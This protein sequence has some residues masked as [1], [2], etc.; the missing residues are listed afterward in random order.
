[1]TKYANYDA[2]QSLLQLLSATELCLVMETDPWLAVA[3]EIRRDRC[4]IQWLNLFMMH[5]NSRFEASK[6]VQAVLSALFD[7]I[8]I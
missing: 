6:A 1:M 4:N 3:D 5:A 8:P 2:L 7:R